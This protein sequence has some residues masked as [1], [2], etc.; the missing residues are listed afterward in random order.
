VTLRAG[1]IV[2]RPRQASVLRMTRTDANVPSAFSCTAMKMFTS[3]AARMVGAWAAVQS[4]RVP[5]AMA[6]ARTDVA[7]PMAPIIALTFLLIWIA[8][9]QTVP[10]RPA[11][12]AQAWDAR[13]AELQQR[14]HFGLHGRVAVAAAGQGFNAKLRWE[15]SGRQANLALDGPLGVGG[16]QVSS[17]GANLTVANS[18]GER[19]DSE[20]ARNELTNRLGFE[21]P[22]ESLRYWIL[23]VPDPAHPAEETLDSEQRLVSLQQNG[24]QI[25]YTKYVAVG[26]RWF[27]EKLTLTRGDVRVRVVVDNWDA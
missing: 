9:C 7:I 21:P 10:T 26:E 24:W 3:R 4:A 23:G 2:A 5:S 25:D 15:Q 6:I 12:R 8:G 18:K 27:P 1:V 16:V 19:L 14:D 11:A 20:A 13:R 22:I 17:D